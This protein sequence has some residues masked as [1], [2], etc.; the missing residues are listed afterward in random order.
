MPPINGTTTRP[1]AISHPVPL[2]MKG[3]IENGGASSTFLLLFDVDKQVNLPYVVFHD[4]DYSRSRT[5][6]ANESNLSEL[7]YAQLNLF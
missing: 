2:L 6:A 3:V 7:D 4:L 5:R 1:A